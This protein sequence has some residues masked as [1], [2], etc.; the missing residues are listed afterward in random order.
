[1]GVQTQYCRMSGSFICRDMR[2]CY[3]VALYDLGDPAL[4]M[5]HL[6]Q[7]IYVNLQVRMSFSVNNTAEDLL[8]HNLYWL[9][10]ITLQLVASPGIIGT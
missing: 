9:Y 5:N 10:V 2:E 7:G 4:A 1:M 6:V 3:A 8:V